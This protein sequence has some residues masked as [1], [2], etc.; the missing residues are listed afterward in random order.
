MHCPRQDQ[1][2]VRGFFIVASGRALVKN[3]LRLR[4]H[5]QGR[6]LSAFVT[7]QSLEGFLEFSIYFI[8]VV[9]EKTLEEDLVELS[10]SACEL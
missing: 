8:I 2:G 1:S 5:P 9:N 10:N 4:R 6:C 7:E 3:P